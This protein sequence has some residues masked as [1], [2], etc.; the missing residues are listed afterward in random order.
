MDPKKRKRLLREWS[1]VKIEL[2]TK[3]AKKK[4]FKDG[5][6]WWAAVGQNIGHEVFGK[7]KEFARPVL[8]F[9][10]TG[11]ETFL[12]VPLST[13]NKT[14]SWYVQYGFKGERRTAI[15]SQIKIM[16]DNRLYNKIGQMDESDM[17][18]IAW[19]LLDLFFS[20]YLN[21]ALARKKF[22]LS[23]GAEGGG[24]SPKILSII[25]QVGRIVKGFLRKK[26]KR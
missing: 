9:K 21:V 7:G 16:S 5:E 10:K 4:R 19:G 3:I 6:I 23:T 12:S 18:N 8:I 24:K 14:G 2:D 13:K 15:L 11:A 22:S 1:E 25:A 17:D 20:D 26:R